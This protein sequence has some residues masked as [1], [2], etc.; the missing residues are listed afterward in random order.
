MTL[1]S[2]IAAVSGRVAQTPSRLAKVRE[3]AECLRA[4]EAAEVPIASAFLSGETRQAV[5]V[6]YAALRAASATAHAPAPELPIADVDSAFTEL[7]A[8]AGSGSNAKRTQRLQALLARATADEQDFL[9]RLIVGELRQGALE[10]VMLEAVAAARGV[11]PA[12]VRRA[13]M[14]AG[15]ARR[16]RAGRAARGRRRAR[17][18][19]DRADAAGAADARAAGADDVAAALARARHGRVRVEARRRARAGPQ[20]RRRRARLHAQAQ[21]RHRIACPEIVEAVRALPRARR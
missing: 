20:G 12:D 11:P 2:T 19:L 9:A 16:R 4:L 8:I 1:F 15:G 7:A 21:R 10:G 18:L 6:S 17:A 5:G 13:A 14:F 3:I